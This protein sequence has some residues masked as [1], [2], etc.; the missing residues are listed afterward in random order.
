MYRTNSKFVKI[1]VRNYIFEHASFEGY[2]QQPANAASFHD[3][4]H[5]IRD[6][7]RAEFRYNRTPSEYAGLID[8]MRGLPSALDTTPI[9]YR[10]SALDVVGSWLDQTET[11]RSKYTETQAEDLALHLIAR[12]L[13]NA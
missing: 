6:I 9:L 3:V 5:T 2:D 10:G 11:E 12:E 8:W 4:A 1:A 7:F 13:L